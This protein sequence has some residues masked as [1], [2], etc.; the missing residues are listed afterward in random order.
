MNKL[1]TTLIAFVTV[2]FS[3]TS[4]AAVN[5]DEMSYLFG[6]ESAIEMQTISNT[7]MATTEGQL[8][9]ITLDTAT[10]FLSLAY[11]YLKPYI[12][13]LSVAF[14]DKA[15]DAIKARFQAFLLSSAI[16]AATAP[17]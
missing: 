4:F 14:K 11:T 10:Q 13:N 1:I 8:F 7:E 16:S 2:T 9:G 12:A 17:Q 3:A 5:Q 15:F 6:T